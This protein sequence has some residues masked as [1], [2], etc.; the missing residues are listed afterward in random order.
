[1]A[2]A[3]TKLSG[4]GFIQ[5]AIVVGIDN[6][7]N[8]FGDYLPLRPYQTLER[9]AFID[10]LTGEEKEELDRIDW[11]ADQYLNLLVEV[12][13]PRVDADFRTLPTCEHTFVIGSSM[14]GLISLYALVEYPQVFGGAGCFSTHWP[15][16]EKVIL[17]YLESYLPEADS[18]RL[19]FDYGSAGYDAEYAPH[20]EAVDALMQEKGYQHG[21][22]W[23]TRLYPGAD[24]HE[25]AWRARLHIAL[26]F[27][28]GHAH[29][30][31]Q[32]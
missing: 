22:D 29:S 14:G 1:M 12:I 19:Y 23:L 17:P 6:S 30:T 9:Q 2:E 7:E 21:V 20:Q 3:I 15:V 13:K 18:H 4:W 27:L 5:P 32:T 26:R 25:L 8:R 11:V 31:T 28:L 24:H 16:V 10:S